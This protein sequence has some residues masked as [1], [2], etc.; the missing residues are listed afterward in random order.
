MLAHTLNHPFILTILQNF[1]PWGLCKLAKS[2]IDRNLSPGILGCTPYQQPAQLSLLLTLLP[3]SDSQRSLD[4][5][6]VAKALAKP[7]T[8]PAKVGQ[9]LF[10]I[11][12]AGTQGKQTYLGCSPPLHERARPGKSCRLLEENATLYA[13]YCFLPLVLLICVTLS[14][15]LSLAQHTG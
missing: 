14:K 11:L 5:M 8:I 2:A 3:N 15:W 6:Q 4:R 10:Q 7:P 1:L 9:T 13:S 12:I